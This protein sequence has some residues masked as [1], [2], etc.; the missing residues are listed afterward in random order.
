[1]P[2]SSFP[3]PPLVHGAEFEELNDWLQEVHHHLYG[4]DTN[5]TGVLDDDNFSSIG[6]GT[7]HDEVS[8][9]HSSVQQATDPTDVI[10]TF[11][12]TIDGTADASYSANEQ[13]L[14][15]DLKEAVNTLIAV[16]DGL[17]DK[18]NTLMANQRT[19]GQL[20]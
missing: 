13:T 6:F 16:V 18:L 19:A 7:L 11:I 8:G 5:L 20:V 14:I 3:A 17:E 12:S 4:L 2:R 10:E 15:N 1:M 9:G